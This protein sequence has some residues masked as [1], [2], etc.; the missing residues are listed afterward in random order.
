MLLPQIA[1]GGGVSVY[2]VRDHP[3]GRWAPLTL[4]GFHV[5]EQ[6]SEAN[7]DNNAQVVVFHW[8]GLGALY[9]LLQERCHD[10]RLLLKRTHDKLRELRGVLQIRVAT[11]QLHAG[12]RP[13]KSLPNELVFSGNARD[14]IFL[15]SGRSEPVAKLRAQRR[16]LGKVDIEHSGHQHL[17]ARQVIRPFDEQRHHCHEYPFILLVVRGRASFVAPLLVAGF[18]AEEALNKLTGGAGQRLSR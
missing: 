7:R 5:L 1:A 10:R 13:E 18:V 4:H 15:M 8:R 3:R 2:A 14:D 17:E 11:E 6:G 9:S 12:S 16:P